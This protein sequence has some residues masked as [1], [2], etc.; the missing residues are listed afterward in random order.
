MSKK[1]YDIIQV[2]DPAD[3]TDLTEAQKEHYQ[4]LGYQ[5][6]V[7]SSGK[8]K[9]LNHSQQV[10]RIV[11]SRP[12]LNIIPNKKKKISSTKRYRRRHSKAFSGFI[13]DNW[14]F[15]FIILLI[16]VGLLLLLKYWNLIFI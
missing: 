5:P 1:K 3:I 15:I 16:V 12:Q 10:S 8:I 7:L 11:K 9:W 14:L 13:R 4:S 6:C 2:L